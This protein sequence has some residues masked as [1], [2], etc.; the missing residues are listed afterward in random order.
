[1]E[2]IL[3]LMKI[4]IWVLIFDIAAASG[5]TQNPFI[6]CIAIAFSAYWY[7]R[8]PVFKKNEKHQED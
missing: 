3:R 5:S 7:W 2:L 8:Y 6:L 1:M 4:L